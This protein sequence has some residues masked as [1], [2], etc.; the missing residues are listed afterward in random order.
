PLS[1]VDTPLEPR[2]AMVPCRVEALPQAPVKCARE[3]RV[4]GLHRTADARPAWHLQ[5]NTRHRRR[6]DGTGLWL[7]LLLI[8]LSLW[9]WP[10]SAFSPPWSA[11]GSSL[12][13]H[14]LQSQSRAK[15]CSRWPAARVSNR[16]GLLAG[17]TSDATRKTD[18]SAGSPTGL[19]SST[20]SQG[21]EDHEPRLPPP[22]EQQQQEM[23]QEQ[24][25]RLLQRPTPQRP[26]TQRPT[27]QRPTQQLPT[28]ERPPQQR[29]PHQRPAL[30][31]Q[32]Q[33]QQEQQ[34][35]Q[36]QTS[37]RKQPTRDSPASRPDEELAISIE[38]IATTLESGQRQS[39]PFPPLPQ[40]QQQQLQLQQQR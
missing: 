26:A 32:Q 15:S 1:A 36:Q 27:Q 28:Q 18:T 34:Q 35:Q 7:A 33:Q 14:P 2:E 30:Q 38:S 12:L 39:A 22:H 40:Q 37:L 13:A 6:K 5:G 23:E 31:Q 10:C 19:A 3:Y 29:P 25:R 9:P 4:Q 17:A 11:A 20:R 8:S 24:E 16:G 21:E